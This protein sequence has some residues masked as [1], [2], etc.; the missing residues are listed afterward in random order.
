MG[1]ENVNATHD[2]FSILLPVHSAD[3]AGR[4]PHDP[5]RYSRFCNGCETPMLVPM[6]YAFEILTVPLTGC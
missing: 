6:D 4:I 5:E 1:R 2:P 3:R